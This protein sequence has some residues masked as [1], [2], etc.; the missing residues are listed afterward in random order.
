MN[1]TR[2]VEALSDGPGT[3]RESIFKRARFVIVAPLVP[4][5]VYRAYNGRLNLK[6]IQLSNW[7]RWGWI[8]ELLKGHV[9]DLITRTH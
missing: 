5:F 8:V 3:P 4:F 6:P 1:K 9:G 7:E 2:T